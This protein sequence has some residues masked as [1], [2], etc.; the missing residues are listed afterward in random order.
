MRN[1]DPNGPDIM[2]APPGW[3]TPPRP[4]NAACPCGATI[5]PSYRPPVF[6]DYR[7][8]AGSGAW[9]LAALCSPCQASEDERQRAAE[10]QEAQTQ[11][12]REIAA[13]IGSS[14]LSRVHGAMEIET[15]KDAPDSARA[16][17]LGWVA[18]KHGLFIHGTPGT[19]KTHAAAAALKARIRRTVA[20]GLF[21]VLPE[22]AIKLRQAAKQHTEDELLSTLS[23]A[24]ALVLDDLGAE[25]MT[26]FVNESLYVLIDRLWRE[27]RRGLIITS[28]YS[29]GELAERIGERLV[30][31]IAALCMTV[32]LEGPDHRL[33]MRPC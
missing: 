23:G 27:E 17:V 4:K 5:A 29:L 8:L 15:W 7:P 31:R 18:G 6:V 11:R 16:A 25:R 14:G 12:R 32:K 9:E 26:P 10:A 21:Q 13:L 1:S 28:N 2:A 24:D 19:G 22:L 30:S 20:P 33:R 3:T